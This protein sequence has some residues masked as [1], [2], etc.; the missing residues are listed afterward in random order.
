MSPPWGTQS[1][2]ERLDALNN[3][4]LLPMIGSRFQNGNISVMEPEILPDSSVGG[5]SGIPSSTLSEYS[6]TLRKPAYT[7]TD[8]TFRRVCSIVVQSKSATT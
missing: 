7:C 6:V 3:A 2:F 8:C 1:V 5:L 4:L